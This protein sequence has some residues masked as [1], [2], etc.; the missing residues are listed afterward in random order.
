[1]N[2]IINQRL[3]RLIRQLTSDEL[4]ALEENVLRDGIR[5]P[6]KLWEH[7]GELIL[8][9]GHNRLALATKHELPYKT[10]TIKAVSI[11]GEELPLD[12]YDRAKIWIAQN[13]KGRRN[14]SAD[15][16]AYLAAS[17]APALAA[18]AKR[19]RDVAAHTG[20]EHGIKGG[21]PSLGKHKTPSRKSAREGSPRQSKHSHR[22]GWT[23]VQAAATAG[24]GEKYTETIMSAAAKKAG[25][26][27]GAEDFNEDAYQAT[28]EAMQNEGLG[29]KKVMQQQRKEKQ[30]EQL[31]LAVAA[32]KPDTKPFVITGDQSTVKARAIIT[33][34]PY[35]ILDEAWE[36]KDVTQLERT[37]RAWLSR[38][39]K[40][41]CDLLLSFWSQAFL[42]QGRKWFDEELS[43]YEFRQVLIWRFKNNNKPVKKGY[44]K[45][46]WEPIFYY[47][48]KGAD[49]VP[50]PGGEA[51]GDDCHNFDSHEAAVPQSNF[52]DADCKAHEAQKPVSVMRWLINAVTQ[53]GDLVVDPFSGSGTTGIAAL[54]LRRLYHG[55]ETQEKHRDL[56]QGRLALYG[57]PFAETAA[58]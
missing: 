8:I 23:R 35:G 36:P 44:F 27:L 56:S 7:N 39:N 19:R 53:P 15:D 1:M 12:S 30:A 52:N 18:E 40:S 57:K 17:V 51:W 49:V 6:L 32:I 4:A 46:S 2:I 43:N 41:G 14:L 42:L 10:S 37:T 48:R 21:R 20:A 24:A 54:Q 25:T 31:A 50:R 38:W 29:A 26:K 5:D 58:A 13:Q 47:V 33:D 28:L 45:R 11:D 16:R 55:I 22:A 3:K 34:P 9:D